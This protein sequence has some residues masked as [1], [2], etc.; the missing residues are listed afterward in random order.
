MK[1]I[2]SEFPNPVLAEGRDDYIETCLFNTSFEENEITVDSKNIS[3]PI[4]YNLE[5]KGLSNLI[6][7][8]DAIVVV[9]VRSNAASYS[10]LFKFDKY[11]TVMTISV[12]KFEVAKKMEVTGLIIAAKNIPNFRCEGEFNDIYFGG[13]TFEIRKGDVLATEEVKSIPVDASELEKPISSIFK[14][15]R[16]EEQDAYVEPAFYNEK[17]EIFLKKDLF[18]L[19]YQLKDFDNGALR[20]FTT[21]IIVYPVLVEAISK[22]INYYQNTEDFDYSEKRWFKT[23]V[24]KAEKKGVKLSEYSDSPTTIA[25]KIL[26]GISLDALSSFKD[27]LD[28]EVNSGESQII[29]G[30]D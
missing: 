15:I 26:N 17:I 30:I 7:T 4:K 23:I 25:D 6:E 24:H 9:L 19:Y 5:C 12:P 2:E 11:Q 16:R 18:D 13:L 29:G 27:T 28:S 3:I 20:R 1:L 21:G 22:I 8:G 10:K 14:I